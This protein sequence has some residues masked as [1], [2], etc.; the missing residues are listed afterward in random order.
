[1]GAKNYEGLADGKLLKS[2]Q[3][4][5]LISRS[6]VYLAPLAIMKTE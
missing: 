1:M 6:L 2:H 5:C 4:H 3:Q